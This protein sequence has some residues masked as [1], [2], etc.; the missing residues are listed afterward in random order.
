MKKAGFTQNEQVSGLKAAVEELK[1][2]VREAKEAAASE[3]KRRAAVEQKAIATRKRSAVLD[4]LA[5][6]DAIDPKKVSRMFMDSVEYD[7]ETDSFVYR[8][9]DDETVPLEE[10]IADE[11][12]DWAIK[13]K[14]GAGGG[15]GSLGGRGGKG[16]TEQP[17]DVVK[18]I[19][20]QI[21][22]LES[23]QRGQ[24][25][26]ADVSRRMQLDRELRA[27]VKAAEAA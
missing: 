26:T 13:A 20:A 19:Q 17:K 18:R 6:L 1:G 5:E 27:A 10:G 24:P 9:T 12:P 4:A 23:S 16:R 8:T 22:E 14:R 7:E 2:Q 15:S 11:L 21:A 3:T 25:S